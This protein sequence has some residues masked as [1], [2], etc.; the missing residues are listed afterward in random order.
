MYAFPPECEIGKRGSGGTE[1][2]INLPCSPGAKPDRADSGEAGPLGRVNERTTS[3]I[4][5]YVNE[6]ETSYNG[7]KEKPHRIRFEPQFIVEPWL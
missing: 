1:E 3:A 2:R 5:G 4:N 6:R 7:E